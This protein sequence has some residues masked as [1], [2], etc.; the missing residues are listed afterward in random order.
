[1]E[2]KPCV[3]CGVQIH[4]AS[5]LCTLCGSPQ[6]RPI[7][8]RVSRPWR[9]GLAG[10]IG[11]VA[12]VVV[13]VVASGGG[14]KSGGA[15]RF[16]L[17]ETTGLTTLVPVGWSGRVEPAPSGTVKAAFAEPA[18]PNYQLSVTAHRPARGTARSRAG[19]A[20]LQAMTRLDYTQHFFGR[21]LFPG[22]RPAWL[23]AY[24]SDGFSHVL[25]VYTACE[26]GVAM[27][28]EV[29]AP[30][31]SDLEGLAAPLAASAGPECG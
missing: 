2:T 30:E 7:G 21:I 14:S 24:E 18:Q 31:R 27:T 29:S 12:V 6:R 9:A 26:P 23:L 28:V 25:Y 22:G 5:T 19:K 10:L 16:R 11:L 8:W 15:T 20:R 13:V 17:F 3:R 4:A 1:V